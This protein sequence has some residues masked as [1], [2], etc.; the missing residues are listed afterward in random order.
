MKVI[1]ILKEKTLLKKEN[2]LKLKAV[3]LNNIVMKW[4][5]LNRNIVYKEQI[6]IFKNNK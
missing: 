6:E 2:K 4:N 5:Y 3:S 1:V